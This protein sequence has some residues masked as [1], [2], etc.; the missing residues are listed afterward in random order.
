MY[1]DDS[2]MEIKTEAV[3]DDITGCPSTAGVFDFTADKFSV[4]YYLYILYL[5]TL[6]LW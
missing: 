2:C 1:I 3:G 5:C 4:L 6:C